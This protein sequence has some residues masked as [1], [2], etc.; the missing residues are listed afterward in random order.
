MIGFLQFY[1]LYTTV[2]D[3]YQ[4]VEEFIH[5]G[6]LVRANSSSSREIQLERKVVGRWVHQSGR[7]T[8]SLKT[9][10]WRLLRTLT[11]SA[12]HFMHPNYGHSKRRMWDTQTSLRCGLTDECWR[13]SWMEKRTNVSILD[14]FR[15]KTRLTVM[16]EQRITRF[17]GRI[18]K[19]DGSSLGKTTIEEKIEGKRSRGK[20]PM[21]WMD[22]VK[23]IIA[24]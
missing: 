22:Q 9:A 15:V 24:G 12:M 10:R 18:I 3:N 20:T 5:P 2:V 21:R 8:V 13:P 19:S 23:T 16:C 11:S 14:M 7:I 4:N 1:I 17:S 6:S